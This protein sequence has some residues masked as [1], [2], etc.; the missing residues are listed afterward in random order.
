MDHFFEND[1]QK[2]EFI[3]QFQSIEKPKNTKD[4]IPFLMAYRKKAAQNNIHFTKDEINIVADI[5]CQNLSIED[6]NRIK[7]LLKY[8]R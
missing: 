2:L 1:P 4:T 7:A 6:Q 3:K 8:I 5:L